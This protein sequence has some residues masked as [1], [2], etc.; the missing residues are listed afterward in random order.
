[1]K[2]NKAPCVFANLNLP[3]KGNGMTNTN[4]DI[5]VVGCLVRSLIRGNKRTNMVLLMNNTPMT[6][7][8]QLN[9][10]TLPPN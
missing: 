1:M 7:R 5:L 4:E 2:R 3:V 8:R 9:R 6:T 10:T